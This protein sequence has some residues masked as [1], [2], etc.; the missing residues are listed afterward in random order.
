MAR[1]VTTLAVVAGLVLTL[2]LPIYPDGLSPLI[3]AFLGLTLVAAVFGLARRSARFELAVM[4][5]WAVAI[6]VAILVGSIYS[7]ESQQAVE[8]ALPYGLFVLGLVAGRGVGSPR[9]VLRVALWVCV[10][11][12]VVS[13]VLMDGFQPG[14]RSTFNYYKITAGLPLVGLYLANVLR[15]TPV[16]ERRERPWGWVPHVL[17]IVALVA[18]IGFSVTRGMLLGWILGMM[19]TA[20]VRKPSHALLGVTIA[21]F[22]LLAW[23]SAFAEFGAEYFRLGQE[24]TIEGRFREVESAWEGF[25]DAPMFGQGLGA[26]V[27][28]DG[29]R[30][31]FVHNMAAYHLWK[32][33]LIGSL[34]LALP[35]VAIARELRFTSR[36]LRAYALGGAAA[37][38][39]YLVTCA[40]YK[41]YYLVWILG[42]VVGA[43]LTWFA[44]WRARTSR[45][46]EAAPPQPPIPDAVP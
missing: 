33:G 12:S 39:A 30:K 31:A 9:L 14:V 3:A 40:A 36:R 26:L 5:P 21:L 18:G 25:V 32:F 38:L 35:L 41:T 34:L 10:V 45:P 46:T 43:S 11:D 15:H 28:V 8:D 23:S 19:V 16:G 44:A 6:L 20:Y 13:L 17:A 7:G 1:I 27:E 42:V 37:V 2:Q 4:T 29:F 22:G 24:G